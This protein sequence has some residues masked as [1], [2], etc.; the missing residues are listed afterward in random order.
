MKWYITRKRVLNI[1]GI[2]FTSRD[3][4]NRDAHSIRRAPRERPDN[5]PFEKE[6]M[7]FHTCT[8]SIS[9]INN[10]VNYKIQCAHH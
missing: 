9:I 10:I 7:G 4:L 6:H 8:N 2:P 5:G 1:D 3:S